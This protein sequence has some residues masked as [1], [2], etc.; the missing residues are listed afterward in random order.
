PAGEPDIHV[1]DFLMEDPRGGDLQFADVKGPFEA[2]FSAVWTGRTESDGFNR[3]VLELGVDWREAALVRTLARYRQQTGLDPSQAVQEE[4][5]RDYPAV[6]RGLLALF[7]AKFD[8]AAGGDGASREAAVA[9]QVDRLNALLQEV[10]S[11]DHDRALRRMV[12]L[13]QAIKR[14]NYYQTGPD[15]APKPHISIKIAS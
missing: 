7:A 4:A 2:A 8:P 10:K 6:A 5:L 12:L 14:T 3:L 9:K 13:V 11:L 1:H 15:G